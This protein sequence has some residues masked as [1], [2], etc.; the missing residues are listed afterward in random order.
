MPYKTEW[1]EPEIF[2]THKGVTV[3]HCYKDGEY[4]RML[5]YWFTVTKVDLADYDDGEHEFDVRELKAFRPELDDDPDAVIRAAIDSGELKQGE[6]R[7]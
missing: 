6:V 5:H 3:W 7:Q 4:D 1:V 2:L